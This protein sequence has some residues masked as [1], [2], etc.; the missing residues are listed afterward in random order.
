MDA[1]GSTSKRKKS[2]RVATIFTGVAACTAGMTQVANAQDVTHAAYKPT[3]KHIGGQVRP[4]AT[5]F[6]SIRSTSGCVNKGVDSH[7]VHA[8][9]WDASLDTSLSMC[10]GYQGDV[11]SPP[12]RGITYECGGNNHGSLLGYSDN[13]TKE[14]YIDYGPGT[15]YAHLNKASLYQIGVWSWAGTDKC[16]RL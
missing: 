4:A 6:G 16:G 10:Y 11:V 14:W 12:G 3:S 5:R 9:W 7:W 13:G 2:M 15:T 1:A 8:Y